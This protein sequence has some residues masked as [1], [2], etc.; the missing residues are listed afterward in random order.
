MSYWNIDSFLRIETLKG[1]EISSLSLSLCLSLF[2]VQSLLGKLVFFFFCFF[3]LPPSQRRT[4]C[5]SFWWGI[6]HFNDLMCLSLAVK[7][8]RANQAA[9]PPLCLHLRASPGLA[10]LRVWSRLPA[11]TRTRRGIRPRLISVPSNCSKSISQLTE[12]FKK[13]II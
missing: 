1:F 2:L 8:W 9:V 13:L 12:T 7:Q 6:I 11:C 10:V 5:P 4:F 3:P